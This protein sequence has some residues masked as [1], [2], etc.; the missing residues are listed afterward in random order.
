MMASTREFLPVR[1][2]EYHS[3]S[4]S[5]SILETDREEGVFHS[6]EKRVS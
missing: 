5:E 2:R 3:R 1:V 4:W 6:R